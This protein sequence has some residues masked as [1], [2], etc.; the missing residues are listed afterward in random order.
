MNITYQVE[1]LKRSSRWDTI[2][3]SYPWMKWERFKCQYL[4]RFSNLVLFD[5][6]ILLVGFIKATGGKIIT[7]DMVPSHAVSTSNSWVWV[8]LV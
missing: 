8:C 5:P 1:G 7:F 3:T 6:F 4:M 2:S